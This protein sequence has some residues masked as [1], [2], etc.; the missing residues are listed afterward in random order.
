VKRWEIIGKLFESY[1]HYRLR[2]KR[3]LTVREVAGIPESTVVFWKLGG[4]ENAPAHIAL[5]RTMLR[6]LLPPRMEKIDR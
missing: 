6:R 1:A 2:R 5:L 4:K 3:V